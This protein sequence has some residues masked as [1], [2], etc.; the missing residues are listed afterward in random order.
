[1]QHENTINSA[2]PIYKPMEVQTNGYL[3]QCPEAA[4]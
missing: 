2:E 1:M 4:V 3:G